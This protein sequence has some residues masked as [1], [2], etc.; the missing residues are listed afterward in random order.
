MLAKRILAC[1]DVHAG[2][3]VKG[4]GFIN[5]ADAGDALQLAEHYVQSGID[6]LVF[7]D[8]TA[9]L[10]KRRLL[11]TL[12]ERVAKA[13]NIPFAVGGGVRTVADAMELLELGADK[14]CINS[15]AVSS[16]ALV[17]DLAMR[18]GSQCIVAAIDCKQQECGYRV[19]TH[20]G[21]C[22]TSLEVL[23]W[24]KELAERGAGEILLTSID[25]DGSKNGFDVGLT[26]AVSK[27]VSIP[28]IAS[29]GAGSVQHFLKLFKQQAA[30]AA[31]AA[32]VFHYSKIGIPQL[33]S[34]LK[35]NGVNVRL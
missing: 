9:T 14:I 22:P 16:P 13:I 32:S 25:A 20:S 31:L 5:L 1:L 33:K 27:A 29:G 23:S 4:S 2:R 24:A 7:L 17:T 6:E 30:D 21:R 26:K 28:V 11:T 3:V 15:A 35:S 8:I 12:V 10:E 34:F 18:F 19:Y